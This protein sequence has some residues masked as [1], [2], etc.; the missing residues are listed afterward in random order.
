MELAQIRLQSTPMKIG[1]HTQQPVQTI[2]QPK[3]IQSI[4]QPQ[5]KLEIE[6]TPG[7]LNIDQTKA[8]EDMD[9]KHISKRVEEAA[10]NGY[11]DFMKGVA[12]RAQEGNELMAIENGGQPIADQAKRNGERQPKPF[13]IGWIPSYFSVKINYEPAK[14][15]INVEP[16][17]PIID[18]QIQ[19]PIHDYQPGKVDVNVE[20]WNSLK[21]DF[22]NLF[23]DSI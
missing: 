18:A 5:A 15:N 23:N 8:W 19:K 11:E 21:I 1:L 2:E 6:T 4:Q 3:A 13:N 17:K 10:Q 12:R 20:Q 14:V 22:T 16:Q 7:K 9:L